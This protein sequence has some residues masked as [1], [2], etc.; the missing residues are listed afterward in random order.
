VPRV[1]GAEAGPD[2]LASAIATAGANLA[3]YR[4]TSRR[5]YVLLLVVLTSVTLITL[6]RRNDDA[7]ALGTVGRAAHTV[8][9]PIER[10]VDSVARPVRN[11][12][13]GVF[14]SGSLEQE[15]RQLR[16]RIAELQGQARNSKSAALEL[17]QLKHATD[18]PVL[19]DVARVVARVVNTS[20]GNFESTITLDRGSSAGVM[21]DMPVLVHDGVVGRVVQ[22]WRDGCKVQ[23]L[24]DPAFNVAVRIAQDRV[25]GIASGRA[26]SSTMNLQLDTN[27]LGIPAVAKRDLVETS[28]FEGSSFPAGLQIGA[29]TE[30]QRQFGGLPPHV[31]VKPFVDFGRLEYVTVLKWAPGQ[32]PVTTTTTTSTTTTTT[33]PSASTP[34]TTPTR[35]ST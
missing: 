30:V 35:P 6:D 4:R 26:G 32:G 13:D 14:S 24:T 33:S 20:A 17:D 7:G 31:R 3:V 11:W 23:L 28:G 34:S 8:V 27:A 19:S 9:S 16:A 1:R 12:F 15:N 21:K 25:T 18:L 29:V 5:R 10:S 22:V 2:L